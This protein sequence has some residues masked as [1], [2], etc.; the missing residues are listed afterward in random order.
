MNVFHDVTK[1]M[2]LPTIFSAYAILYRLYRVLKISTLIVRDKER[3]KG[4]ENAHG[5][6]IM[7][8]LVNQITQQLETELREKK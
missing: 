4:M 8:V 6:I 1:S 7:I 5:K 2:Y 3:K